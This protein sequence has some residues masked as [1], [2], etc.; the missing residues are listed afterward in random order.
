MKDPIVLDTCVFD[1]RDFI[2][3]LRG[4]RGKKVL[5]AV[6]FCELLVYLMGKRGRTLEQVKKYLKAADITVEP[7]RFGEAVKAA[8]IGIMTGDFKENA[9]DIMIAS[10][11][12]IAPWKLITFN[13][14]DF[15]FLGDRVI[16]PQEFRD[17]S[18]V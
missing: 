12:A 3:R 2:R 7:F 5:P 6:A 8:E 15:S 1:D 11:A 10:H 17:V 4:Y 9:R 18:G 16:S 13:K 14:K